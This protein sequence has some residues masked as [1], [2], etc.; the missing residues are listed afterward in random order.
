MSRNLMKIA[1]QLSKRE[2]FLI[3]YALAY[4][5]GKRDTLSPD[6]P[7]FPEWL[8]FDTEEIL[9]SLAEEEAERMKRSQYWSKDK[10][11]SDQEK[12]LLKEVTDLKDKL[13]KY[14]D[15]VNE[16]APE[17]EFNPGA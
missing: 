1:P 13:Q 6:K 10:E 11:F 12:Y 5:G 9:K 7:K 17:L 4:H 3:H 14:L 15:G 16:A 2:I 8:L